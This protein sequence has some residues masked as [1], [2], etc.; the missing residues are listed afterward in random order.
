MIAHLID[1]DLKDA[2]SAPSSVNW[3]CSRSTPFA[4]AGSYGETVA[5]IHEAIEWHI[6]GMLLH[7]DHL[8]APTTLAETGS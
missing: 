1:D 4:A 3:D 7:G 8:P 5:P 2:R 6:E